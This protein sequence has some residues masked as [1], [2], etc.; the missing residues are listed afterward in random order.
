MQTEV[1][2]WFLINISDFQSRAIGWATD[3]SDHRVF[4]SPI[5]GGKA[6]GPPK[7]RKLQDE[8]QLRIRSQTVAVFDLE[9]L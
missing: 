5:R 6:Q 2:P 3:R 4:L 8:Q 9:A 7:Y 1:I